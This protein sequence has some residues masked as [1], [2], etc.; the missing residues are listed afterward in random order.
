MQ[1][2]M[3]W[4]RELQRIGQIGRQS[5]LPTG[6]GDQEGGREQ[7]QGRLTFP[8]W[9]K[10]IPAN[11]RAAVCGG[12]PWGLTAGGATREFREVQCPY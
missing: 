8:C 2:P 7:Q 4:E 3:D 12:S 10:H 6:H 11:G 1:C 9:T 5:G